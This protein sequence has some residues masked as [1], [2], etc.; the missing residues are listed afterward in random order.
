MTH[1]EQIK[2]SL[3]IAR[4]ALAEETREVAQVSQRLNENLGEAVKRIWR[5]LLFIWAV[6]IVLAG[7]YLAFWLKGSLAPVSSPQETVIRELTRPPA[8]PADLSQASVPDIPEREAL[9]NLL[10]QIRE[11]QLKKDI[12]LFMSAYSPTFPDKAQ[13]R[14]HTLNIWRRYDY[15]D[16]QFQVKDVRSQDDAHMSGKVTWIIKARD[17]KDDDVKTVRKTYQVQFS[18]NAGYWLIQDLEALEDKGA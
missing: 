3:E 7:S 11:A 14:L 2:K 4:A 13:K 12:Q 8:S 1:P 16:L 17:R 18:K 10:N 6:V 15:I 9:L 5:Q